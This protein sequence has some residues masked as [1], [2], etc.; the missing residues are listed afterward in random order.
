MS[1]RPGLGSN[2]L[3]THANWHLHGKRNYTQVNG[4]KGRIPRYYKDALFSAPLRESM[5]TESINLA[6]I[7]YHQEVEQ[8]QKFHD[9][10]YYY[11]DERQRHAHDSVYDKINSKDMF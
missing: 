2:Y 7:V 6:D 8:L 5:A 11:Y 10:P 4:I 1:R 9:D 3:V